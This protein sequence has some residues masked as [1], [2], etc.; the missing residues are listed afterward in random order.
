M[1]RLLLLLIAFV[2]ISFGQH[3]VTLAW[4]PGTGGDTVTGFHVQRSATSGGPYTIIATVTSPTTT[5]VDTAVVAGQSLFYVVTAFNTGGESTPS[6]QA[7]CVVPFQAP[8]S[9]GSLSATVK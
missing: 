2:G 8:T 9:P 4:T 7:S 3:S 6:P 5:Y 1:K